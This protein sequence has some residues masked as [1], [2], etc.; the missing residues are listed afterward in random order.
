MLLLISQVPSRG[1]SC[2]AE[3][4]KSGIPAIAISPQA[5]T[6]LKQRWDYG[7]LLVEAHDASFPLDQHS[8]E[9]R[10]FCLEHGYATHA[11]TYALQVNAVT[12]QIVYLGYPLDLTPGE[13]RLL[14]HLLRKAPATVD[15]D[16]LTAVC[17]SRQCITV[18]RL[19]NLISSVNRKAKAIS[20]LCLIRSVRG[21]GYR[22]A[23]GILRTAP[24]E[25]PMEAPFSEEEMTIT[26]DQLR[27]Y[28]DK[29]LFDK[30]P[31]DHGNHW[32]SSHTKGDEL[33]R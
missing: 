3:L 10:C 11:E 28:Q 25:A 17:F 4:Q 12:L 14:I 19:T 5:A 15:I 18:S 21:K 9:I 8:N 2:A 31:Y 16:E 33:F 1:A 23:E 30:S 24:R 22:L 13:A 26:S 27:F 29:S 32:K 7:G 20:G 6:T